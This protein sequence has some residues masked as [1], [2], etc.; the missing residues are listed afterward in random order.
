MSDKQVPSNITHSVF[1][2]H[3]P[4]GATSNRVLQRIKRAYGLKKAGH[5]GAL[6]PLATGVLPLCFGEAT[7]FSQFGLDSVKCYRV[8]AK[9]GIETN[10]GDSDGE[11]IAT[12]DKPGAF[13]EEDL[14]SLIQSFIGVQKQTPSPF[15]ALKYQG[16]PLYEYA[17]KGIEVPIPTRDICISQINIENI[18][19][20]NAK[21]TLWVQASKGTYIRSLIQDIGE[22]SGWGAHVTML[23]RTHAGLFHESACHKVDI[24]DRE[25]IQQIQP[26]P[27]SVLA[28]ELPWFL[29]TGDAA[30]GLDNGHPVPLDSVIDL[31]PLKEKLVAH[32]EKQGLIFNRN[33]S[34]PMMDDF[35]ANILHA[36]LDH[37]TQGQV[38]LFVA[39]GH[40][41][42][43]S[44]CVNELEYEVLERKL[45]LRGLAVLENSFYKAKRLV[46]V[47]VDVF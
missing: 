45:S 22:K 35:Y 37:D 12:H 36:N 10:T 21:M 15:S 39:R 25:A 40:A 17:R 27:V 30:R 44:D 4:Q 46:S 19:F 1:L 7:K 9:L 2:C 33:T 24:D 11:V 38:A 43:L 18:D 31:N 8:T 13:S 29:V 6:D 41:K 23:H 42:D 5:T 20:Q 26:L 34:H 14:I 3:K 28:L 47:G 16:K 32:F